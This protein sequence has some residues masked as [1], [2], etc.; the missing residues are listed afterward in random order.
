MVL[1]FLFVFSDFWPRL[2][3]RRGNGATHKDVFNL[4]NSRQDFNENMIMTMQWLLFLFLQA[5]NM[6][7]R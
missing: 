3:A 4:S 2:N 6:G 5:A 1:L 7:T